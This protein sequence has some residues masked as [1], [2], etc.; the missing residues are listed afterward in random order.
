M[1]GTVVVLIRIGMGW[2]GVWL[3]A[4][5]LP[6]PLVDLLTN[7]PATHQLLADM[8]GQVIG[9]LLMLAQLAW[10]QIAKRMRWAT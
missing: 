2:L 5:G 8:V 6:A 1:T 10:W 9:G 4:Q 7:D 3:T